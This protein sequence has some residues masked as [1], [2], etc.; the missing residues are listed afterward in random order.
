MA[1]ERIAIAK[2]LDFQLAPRIRGVGLSIIANPNPAGAAGSWETLQ[3]WHP[4]GIR[5]GDFTRMATCGTE[6]GGGRPR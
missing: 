6:R 3:G 4:G 5:V 2:V 1:A